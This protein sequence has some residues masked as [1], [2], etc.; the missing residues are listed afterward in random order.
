MDEAYPSAE[1]GTPEGAVPEA[2]KRTLAHG[3]CSDTSKEPT[4][5]DMKQ[6][7]M[8]DTPTTEEARVFEGL[9]PTFVVDEGATSNTFSQETLLQATAPKIANLDVTMSNEFQDQFISQYSARIFPWALN[10]DCGG[11]DYPDLFANWQEL[12]QSLGNEA[13]SHLKSRWRRLEASAPLLPGPYAKMLASRAEL[14]I[15]GDWMVVPA[16]RNLHWRYTVLQSAFMISK[17]KIIPGE[18]MWQYTTYFIFEAGGYPS[19]FKAFLSFA[20]LA[21]NG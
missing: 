18:S 2:I 16:A 14:Q 17:Q 1:F 5:F 3:H 11:A 13:V 7:A 15:A 9:R 10:Y 21:K 20:W 8:P 4:A 6:S 12:E 19:V